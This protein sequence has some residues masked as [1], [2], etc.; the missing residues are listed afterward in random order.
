MAAAGKG[1]DIHIRTK[2]QDFYSYITKVAIK[3]GDE[4]LEIGHNLVRLAGVLQSNPL[5][6]SLS[7]S[8]LPVLYEKE[9]KGNDRE[10]HV[11]RIILGQGEFI[12]VKVFK[13][14]ISVKIHGASEGNFA[15][16]TGILGDFYTG[17]M[18]GRDGVTVVSDPNE[19][20]VEWQVNGE[21]PQLFHSKEEPQFPVK[22]IPAQ[23][24]EAGR[25]LRHGITIAKAEEA[26]SDWGDDIEDCV[27]DVMATGDL[28]L[29]GAF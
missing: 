20:G 24:V 13:L 18:L 4:V 23:P 27:F 17:R 1:L 9:I 28:D 25:Q 21:D 22:C 2:Q 12:E 5:E 29:A 10:Q 6:S 26:C 8:G 15:D 7:L 16:S 11:Y 19:F 3:I 14:F